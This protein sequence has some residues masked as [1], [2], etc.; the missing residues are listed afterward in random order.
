MGRVVATISIGGNKDRE[1]VKTEAYSICRNPLYFSSFL[2][3]LGVGLLSGRPDFML[4]AAGSFLAIFY[5]MMINEAGV[6]RRKFDDFA[7]Y[8]RKVP[9]FFPN[10]MLWSERRNFEI[11]FR[12]VRRT[13]L[14]ASIALPV[15]PLMIL[16]HALR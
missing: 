2:M 10:I 7:E 1:I 16:M 13:L 15:I 6:L 14:D 4:L 12:L 5:P 11:N 3:A 9:L 8:E